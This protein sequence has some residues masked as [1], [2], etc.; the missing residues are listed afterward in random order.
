MADGNAY[1]A[2][3]TDGLGV[4]ERSGANGL[5]EE[6]SS[7]AMKTFFRNLFSSMG[8]NDKIVGGYD[9]IKRNIL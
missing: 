1:F 4:Q 8:K 3:K 5:Q 9:P 6:I 7:K 2:H